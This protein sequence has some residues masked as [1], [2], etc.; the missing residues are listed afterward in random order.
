MPAVMELTLS[1]LNQNQ[2]WINRWNYYVAPP[3]GVLTLAA[4]MITPLGFVDVNT[5]VP[6]FQIGAG[7]FL[8]DLLQMTCNT[9]SVDTLQILNV[10]DPLD[11]YSTSIAPPFVGVLAQPAASPALTH[12]FRSSVVRRDIRPGQ[13]AIGGVQRDQMDSGGGFNAAHLTKMQAFAARMSANLEST[14]G[15][16][17]I[18]YQPCVVKKERYAVSPGDPDTTYAYRYP[19]N[20]ADLLA[21]LAIGVTWSAISTVRTQVSRQYGRGI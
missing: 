10:R 8:Y 2:R 18:T 5:G 4:G 11:F 20:E 17:T 9:F 15:G 21:N 1:G 16:N 7:T 14:V 12:K 3:A 13:K 6:G 19:V